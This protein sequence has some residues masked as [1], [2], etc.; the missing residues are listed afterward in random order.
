MLGIVGFLPAD[1]PRLLATIEQIERGLSDER[2][3]LYRYRGPDGFASTE[4]TFLLCTFCLAQALALT[5]QTERARVVLD[6]AASYA[7]SLGLL[8]EQVDPSI[9]ELLGNLPQAF[10][11]LGLV[12][13]AAA[14]ADA[15]SCAAATDSASAQS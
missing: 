10:S 14:L 1:D 11:H 15:G 4:G 3:L 12:N 5:G 13:A 9:G 7:S 2:G 8:A 6:R